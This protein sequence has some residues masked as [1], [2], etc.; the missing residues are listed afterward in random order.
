[1][2]I[3]IRNVLANCGIQCYVGY[4]HDDQFLTRYF[5]IQHSFALP[6]FV[7]RFTTGQHWLPTNDYVES[8]TKKY[9]FRHFRLH[10]IRMFSTCVLE[11]IVLSRVGRIITGQYVG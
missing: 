1:M 9:R 4:V 6:C 3:L 2:F 5:I 11:L 8:G 10:L 7:I